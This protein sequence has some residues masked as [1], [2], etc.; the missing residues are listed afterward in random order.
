MKSFVFVCTLSVLALTGCNRAGAPAAAAA[1]T[2]AEA[3][4]AV[5]AAEAAWISMDAAKVESVYA[6][7]VVGFDF[8]DPKLSTTW[9][10]WHRLQEGFAG[11]KL[12]AVTVTDRKLQILDDEDF[13]ESGTATF[14]SKDGP[15]KTVSMRFTDVYRK[16]ADGKFLIVNEH[17][18]AI[19]TPPA[20]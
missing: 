5:A 6:Q 11:M 17:V 9:E 19:P 18:S 10:N 20:T 4:T 2:E 12:D 8:A 16:Q 14:T 3:Q 1:I 15:M 13:I 7:D